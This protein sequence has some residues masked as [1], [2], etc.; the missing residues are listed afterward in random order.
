MSASDPNSSIFLTDSDK[1]IKTKVC[2][3]IP[4]TRKAADIYSI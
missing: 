3:A 1:Q 2:L 4:S